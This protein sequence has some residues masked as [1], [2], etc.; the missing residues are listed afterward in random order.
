MQLRSVVR[1]GV[2]TP[3]VLANGDIS[4]HLLGMMVSVEEKL[5]T[6]FGKSGTSPAADSYQKLKN[7]SSNRVSKKSSNATKGKKY[8]ICRLEPYENREVGLSRSTTAEKTNVMDR[9][10]LVGVE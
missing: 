4:P 7:L 6:S 8:R 5:D 10:F 1:N 2:D 3:G 9:Y